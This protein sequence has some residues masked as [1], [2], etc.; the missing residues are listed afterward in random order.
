[1]V[2]G[3]SARP[4]DHAGRWHGPNGGRSHRLSPSGLTLL[5]AARDQGRLKTKNL[6]G[7]PRVAPPHPQPHEGLTLALTW[8]SGHAFHEIRFHQIE[9]AFSLCFSSE[10]V[11]VI[12]KAYS[13]L[14]QPKLRFLS[15]KAYF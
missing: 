14:F 4:A 13:S 15:Q 3:G 12:L 8:L 6:P 1:M 7:G 9:S 5:S 2:K 11:F 10:Y